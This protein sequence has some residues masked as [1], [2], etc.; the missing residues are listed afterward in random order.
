MVKFQGKDSSMMLIKVEQNAKD[1]ITGTPV[2][3]NPMAFSGQR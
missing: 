1:K 3:F 2:P